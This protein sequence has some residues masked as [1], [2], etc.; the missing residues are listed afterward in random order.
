MRQLTKRVNSGWRRDLDMEL[1]IR[2]TL[3]IADVS[4]LVISCG[5][6]HTCWL[7]VWAW[8]LVGIALM[9]SSSEQLSSCWLNPEIW[10]WMDQRGPRSCFLLTMALS[11]AQTKQ[12]CRS[13]RLVS[14]ADWG[15]PS[16]QFWC[17]TSAVLLPTFTSLAALE[18]GQYRPPI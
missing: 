13:E 7:I 14:T 17:V 4:G 2:P 10:K 6:C 9:S 15:F 16:V 5:L 1:S 11:R 12:R 3:G 8:T 18:C